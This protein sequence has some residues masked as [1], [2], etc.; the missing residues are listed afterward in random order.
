[1]SVELPFDVVSENPIVAAVEVA[2]PAAEAPRKER[3][4]RKPREPQEA[5]GA[6]E[7]KE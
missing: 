6:P 2:P 7:K 4:E 3:K 1:V 5:K